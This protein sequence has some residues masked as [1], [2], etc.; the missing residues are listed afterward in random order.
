MRPWKEIVGS[1]FLPVVFI[2]SALRPKSSRPE[3]WSL[4]KLNF[5]IIHVNRIAG[6]LEWNV[7]Q[8]AEG[9]HAAASG[10]M[11]D[12]DSYHLVYS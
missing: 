6:W 5:T 12:I 3:Q 2:C 9:G 8:R 1:L 4:A 11:G 7:V 10:V